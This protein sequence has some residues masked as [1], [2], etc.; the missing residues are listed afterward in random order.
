MLPLKRNNCQIRHRTRVVARRPP[1]CQALDRRVKLGVVLH[2]GWPLPAAH[3]LI[4]T[5]KAPTPLLSTAVQTLATPACCRESQ[6]GSPPWPLLADALRLRL[7]LK[8]KVKVKLKLKLKLKVK[9][10]L[11]LKLI[12]SPRQLS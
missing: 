12:T 4:D 7:R 3:G 10:K 8:V 9:V 6:Y 2:A 5:E 11:K 1:L